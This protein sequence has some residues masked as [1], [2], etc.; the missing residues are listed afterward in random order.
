MQRLITALIISSVLC[1]CD[2]ISPKKSFRVA[3]QKD[4]YVHHQ[5]FNHLDTLLK[6]RG[7]QLQLIETENSIKSFQM[8]SS[9][10]AELTFVNNHSYRMMEILGPEASNLRA[11]MPIA[12]RV[13]LTFTR[14]PIADTTSA[15]SIFSGKRIGIEELGGEVNTTL[16]DRFKR[17]K[18]KGIKFVSFDDE[19]EILVYWGALYGKRAEGFE[20]KGWYPVSFNKDWIEFNTEFDEALEPINIAGVPG[21]PLSYGIKTFST[22]VLMVGNSYLGETACYELAK[23]IFE[24]RLELLSRERMYATINENF[25]KSSLL[26]PLHDGTRSYILRDQPTLLERYADAIALLITVMAVIYGAAQAIKRGILQ[27]RKDH[28]D[29]YFLEYLQIRKYSSKD[30]AVQKRKLTELHHKAIVQMTKEKLDKEDFDI[31]S[32]MIQQ[33]LAILDK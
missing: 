10:D 16:E 24:N 8:V 27:K 26:L 15:N 20:K 25:D 23:T 30:S 6:K 7:Y 2:M 19:P 17:A 1:S 4:T 33:E 5:I 11:V 14:H 22:T 21:D 13:F 3:I 31:L 28:L 32:Q 12:K 9:G 18:I 29:T